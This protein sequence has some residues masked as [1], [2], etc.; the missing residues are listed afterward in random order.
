MQNKPV[1]TD[2]FNSSELTDYQARTLLILEIAK[3]LLLRY[4]YS[5]VTVDDIAEQ[6]KLGKGTIYLHW[7]SKEDLFYA[8]LAKTVAEIINNIL[9]VVCKN[10]EAVMLDDLICLFYSLSLKEKILT[11]L[12]TKDGKL[13]GKLIDYEASKASQKK[14][15]ESLRTSIDLYRRYRLIKTDASPDI[16]AHIINALIVGVLHYN[17]YLQGD[18]NPQEQLAMI[19]TVIRNTFIPDNPPPVP[20]EFHLNIC[21]GFKE[22][23][24]FYR[25][26]IFSTT[27]KGQGG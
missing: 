21:S 11:A 27:V 9:T 24:D 20:E 5:K 14:K 8:L 18:L 23:Q 16:Q 17:T 1:T 10:A 6:A 4:G 19:K 7:K 22:L 2:P 13:L 12:F 26:M 3:P 25:N 15:A